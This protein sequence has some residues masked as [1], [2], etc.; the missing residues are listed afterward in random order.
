MKTLIKIVGGILGVALLGIGGLLVWVSTALPDIDPAPKMTIELTEERI[1]NGKY[2]AH[3]V[4]VCMDCHSG[5]EYSRFALAIQEGTLGQGG[6]LFGEPDFPGNYYASNLTPYHLGNWT[7]GEIFRAITTGVSKNGRALF[8][9]MPYTNYR[10]ADPEDI[11]DII[12]YLRTLEPIEH[13]V[14]ESSSN[15]PMNFIINTIP[16]EASLTKRPKASDKIKYGQY[17]TTMASCADCH[18]PMDKGA[19]IP[20]M[21]FAG[22]TNFQ[23]PGGVVTSANITPDMETGIGSWTEE[24]FIAR[25]LQ[26]TDSTHVINSKELIP[27]QM[28]TKMPWRFYSNM[29]EEELGAI[30]AYLRTIKPVNNPIDKWAPAQ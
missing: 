21:A 13:D 15:F 25:F 1:A 2:L 8:P 19:P 23:V 20:G 18:T 28:Q 10:Q 26:F 24:V 9:I 30:Y 16:Q 17:L 7:D 29:S 14:P 22:G 3:N 6:N 12:A 4:F 5:N 11:K 27:G